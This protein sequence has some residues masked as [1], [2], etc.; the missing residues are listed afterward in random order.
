MSTWLRNLSISN[1]LIVIITSI[2]LVIILLIGMI[3]VSSNRRAL[4]SQATRRF[5]EKN[6]QV[7][8]SIMA[9]MG[10][11]LATTEQIGRTLSGL[12]NYSQTQIRSAINEIIS[13]DEDILIHRVGVYRPALPDQP[14]SDDSVVV[15]QIFQ[16]RTGVINETRTFTYDNQ[17]PASD[18]PMFAALNRNQPVWFRLAYDGLFNG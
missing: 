17:Q 1:R 16:P 3:A 11:V 12:Q 9:E 5:A 8:S 15:L 7:A 13:Q 18:A 2:N 14:E 10:S 4:E 6:Q